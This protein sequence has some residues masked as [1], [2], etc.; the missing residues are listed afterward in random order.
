M[1]GFA[2]CAPHSHLQGEGHLILKHGLHPLTSAMYIFWS[3]SSENLPNPEQLLV[4][5]NPRIFS[6]STKEIVY[7]VATARPSSLLP[8]PTPSPSQPQ[9]YI[10]SLRIF[11]FWDVHL[12]NILAIS[13]PC[14]ASFIQQVFKFHPQHAL[15]CIYF[16][17]LDNT[18]LYEYR[19]IRFCL[20]IIS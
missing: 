10:T 19:C 15:V 16:L 4:L 12:L 6:L 14:L 2:D 8:T 13:P 18:P 20:S 3:M 17:R 5:P 1:G 9:I 7:L 11:Q